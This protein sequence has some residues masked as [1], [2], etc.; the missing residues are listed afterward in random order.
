MLHYSQ[1]NSILLP[2]YN[3]EKLRKNRIKPGAV[4]WRITRM[5]AH[6]YMTFEISTE[7]LENS[8]LD[9][10]SGVALSTEA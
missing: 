9:R 4:N 2:I 5:D 7:N 3:K 1:I 6:V 8:N 10:I